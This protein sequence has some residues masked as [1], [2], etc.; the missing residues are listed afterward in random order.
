[1]ATSCIA[2]N[3]GNVFALPE[4]V[5]ETILLGVAVVLKCRKKEN[6]NKW[7]D[8]FIIQ[9]KDEFIRMKWNEFV[10]AGWSF[11]SSQ[12]V[13]NIDLLVLSSV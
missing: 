11:A 9:Q 6:E 13:E 4:K 2:Q 8:R 5:L 10:A 7:T 12:L 3:T 1:M